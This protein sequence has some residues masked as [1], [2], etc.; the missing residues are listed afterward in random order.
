MKAVE[1]NK[2]AEMAGSL[3]N[4]KSKHFLGTERVKISLD[5]NGTKPPIFHQ[6][7]V[8]EPDSVH[9]RAYGGHFQ[10]HTVVVYFSGFLLQWTMFCYND[11]PEMHYS[12][13]LSVGI[14]SC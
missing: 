12:S 13:Q 11:G 2:S 10:G 3:D 8:A 6:G 14:P 5:R 9:C 7:S 1:F 4:R